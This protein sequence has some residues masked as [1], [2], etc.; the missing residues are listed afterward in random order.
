MS[1]VNELRAEVARL[2]RELNPEN[3]DDV[4][5]R[6]DRRIEDMTKEH[7]GEIRE[8]SSERNRFKFECRRLARLVACYEESL[9]D[10]K[11]RLDEVELEEMKGWADCVD[12]ADPP[13]K[14]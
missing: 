10:Y 12:T 9:A 1:T 11:D 13:L 5:Y 14:S 6:L 8:L 2:R 7:A 4:I 3:P